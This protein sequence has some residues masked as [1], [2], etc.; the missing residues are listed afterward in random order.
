[1]AGPIVLLTD[2]GLADAY[3]G[4][5]KGVILRV[6]PGATIVDLCH[7]VPPQAVEEGAFLL[8]ES[9]RYF[10]EDAVFVAVV[11]PG[12]GSERRAIVLRTPGGT[13]VGPDNG[14]LSLVAAEYGVP[15]GSAGRSSL[16]ESSVTG[17]ILSNAAYFLPRVSATFHGRDVF[18][19]VAGHLS[20]GVPLAAFGPPL[21]DIATLSSPAVE[22]RAD[23]IVGHVRRVDRFGNAITDISR[24][25]LAD[26]TMPV[27][28]VAGQRIAGLSHHYAEK[29]DLLALLGSADRLEIAVNGGSA[30]AM[31]GLKVGDTVVVRERRA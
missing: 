16:A 12:V 23:Q 15:L 20:A 10:P 22:R 11:D 24:A 27:V 13:F 9:Y 25:D 5:M 6:N 2:F 19:P 3:V 4:T 18:A 21:V 8:A 31:L 1:V 30:A 29:C 7:E 28:E 14:I 17:V 26:L